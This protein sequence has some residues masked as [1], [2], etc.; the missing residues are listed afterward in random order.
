MLADNTCVGMG[1]KELREEIDRFV[2]DMRPIQTR[3]NELAA[4]LITVCKEEMKREG[5]HQTTGQ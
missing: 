2:S 3:I 5:I 1:S 4:K